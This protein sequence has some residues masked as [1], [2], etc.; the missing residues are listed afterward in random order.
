VL[1]KAPAGAGISA[2]R[3]GRAGRGWGAL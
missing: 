3:L 1:P 2:W